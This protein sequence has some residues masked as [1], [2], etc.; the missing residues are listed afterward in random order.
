MEKL[1]SECQATKTL[2]AF[3]RH[4]ATPDGR[5]YI[6]MDCLRARRAVVAGRTPEERRQRQLALIRERHRTDP[7]YRQRLYGHQRKSVYGLS[8]EQFRALLDRQSGLCAICRETSRDSLGRGLQVDHDHETARIRGLLCH[9]CNT[10]IGLFQ[11]DPAR[12]RSAL[13]YLLQTGRASLTIKPPRPRVRARCGTVSGYTRHSRLGES[14]CESCLRAWR[15]YSQ[16]TRKE[17]SVGRE[18]KRRKVAICGTP[19]GATAHYN[20][21]E[22][23]CAAC[24]E[25]VRLYRIARRSKLAT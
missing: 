13:R 5:G 2:D 22:P 23:S 4:A 3:K 8:P 7:E 12:L 1:C 9:A 24:Q 14:A 17:R 25:A 16:K 18:L 10:A 19:S 20:R 11:E 6:C 15:E 21:H